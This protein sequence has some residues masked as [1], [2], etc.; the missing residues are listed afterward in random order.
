MMYNKIYYTFSF[1][2]FTLLNNQ[3]NNIT[4]SLKRYNLFL[5]VWK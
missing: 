2:L 3:L 1:L 4:V 5:Q